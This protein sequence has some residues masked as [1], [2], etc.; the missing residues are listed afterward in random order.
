MRIPLWMS[1]S[2][3][4]R[5]V[6]PRNECEPP[7]SLPS[8]PLPSSPIFAGITHPPSAMVHFTLAANEPFQCP[9]AG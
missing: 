3:R 4:L 9:D 5:S 7:A 6:M 2:R 1:Q 8:L